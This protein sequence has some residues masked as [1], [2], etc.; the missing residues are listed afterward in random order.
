M[1]AL[2]PPAQPPPF[3][4]V[5]EHFLAAL[6]W[7]VAA[8]AGLVIV[9]PDLAA[10]NIFAP[11]ALAATHALTLGVL[12]TMIFGALYQFFPNALGVG[13]RSIPVAH[14]TFWTLQAGVLTLTIGFWWWIPALLLAGWLLLFLAVGGLAWNLLPQ[15]RKATQGRI[16]GLYVSAGHMMLGLAMAL[17]FARI[18]EPLGWWTVSRTGMIA[19][20]Y[21]L[22][23][24]GFVTLTIVGVGSRMVP[25]FLFAQQAPQWPVRVIGPMAAAGL[26]VQA[27]GLIWSLSWATVAGGL[28]VAAAGALIVLQMA[29]WLHHR[30][31]KAPD[32]ATIHLAV[33][34]GFLL[35]A[36]VAGLLLLFATGR[37]NP[38]AWTAYGLIGMLGWM[39][40]F[41]LGIAYRIVP[42]LSWLHLFG[43]MGRGAHAR[44]AHLLVHRGLAWVTLLSF[45]FGTLSCALGVLRG[46][47]FAA[48]TGAILILLGALGVAGQLL[49]GWLLW[50]ATPRDPHPASEPSRSQGRPLP[51]LS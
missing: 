43:G 28:L 39:T 21:H 38:R 20:H 33:A 32:H 30:A 5:G 3:P 22:A 47:A 18:G 48:T 42:F 44:P 26:L 31:R 50:R 45:T 46:Q 16:V 29:L 10:G 6:L 15:R 13:A 36:I 7:L 51:V 37:F 11:R 12:T 41:T 24:L 8:A 35:A 2:S 40:I 34:T 23:A 14:R 49:R 19:A 27:T 25:M 17:A 4:L 9:A 1:A